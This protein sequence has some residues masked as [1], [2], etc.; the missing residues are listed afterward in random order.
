MA[1]LSRLICG[2]LV[3]G[4]IAACGSPSN[5]S[6]QQEQTPMFS[7]FGKK[8]TEAA[9]T[10]VHPQLQAELQRIENFP[11]TP[12]P[13]APR[14]TATC[15]KYAVRGRPPQV[16][17]EDGKDLPASEAA[18]GFVITGRERAVL[19]MNLPDN[20][21]DASIELWQLASAQNLQLTRKLPIQLH[22]DA[23]AWRAR[24]LD[25]ALCLPNGRVLVSI[26]YYAPRRRDGLFLYDI[27]QQRFSRLAEVSSY[28]S[29]FFEPQ[30]LNSEAAMLLYFSDER[31][32][33]AEIYHNYYNHFH[34]FTRAYP[35]GLEVLKLGID[36]GNA[37]QWAVLDKKLYLRTR[38]PRA[39][40]NPREAY[41]S[42]DL[43]K[44]LSN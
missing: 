13:P 20:V 39:P 5:G 29:K 16:K 18:I 41:W 36:I 19:L 38:D 24:F 6:E 31:R 25:D 35:D 37:T 2:C 26:N 22:P 23:A 1:N 17:L 33:A 40:E 28:R 30:L 44:L 12:V 9:P 27:G 34:L 32:K 4:L 14:L 15:T 8:K 3:Y 7:L 42:L 11:A 43:S 21:P 10:T